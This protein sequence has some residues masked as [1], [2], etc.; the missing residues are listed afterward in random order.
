[1]KDRFLLFENEDIVDN[2]NYM[3]W[4][5]INYASAS[6]P[7]FA[8]TLPSTWM[9]KIAKTII[10]SNITASD[11]EWIIINKDLGGFYRV[12]YDANN[13]GLIRQQLMTDHEVVV[14]NNRAQVLDDSLNI[15]RAGKIFKSAATM[16]N[17]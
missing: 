11:D 9:S 7:D 8:N 1:M 10:I 13:W 12:N 16:H 5:P 17:S 14:P 15:A 3:W 4:I 2:H 6:D